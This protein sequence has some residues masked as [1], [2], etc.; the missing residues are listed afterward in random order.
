MLLYFYT[1]TYA[2]DVYSHI[3]DL[4]HIMHGN[5]LRTQLKQVQKMNQMAMHIHGNKRWHELSVK[6]QKS[7]TF[8]IRR[9]FAF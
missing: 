4:S 8:V 1:K 3:G 5:I 2:D 9:G 6:C 7:F